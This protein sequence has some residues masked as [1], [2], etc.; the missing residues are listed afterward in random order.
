MKK[1]IILIFCALWAFFLNANNK[2][3]IILIY[4]DDQGWMDIGYQTKGQFQLQP[5]IKWPERG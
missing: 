5:L 2:P 3:N 1:N 4:A